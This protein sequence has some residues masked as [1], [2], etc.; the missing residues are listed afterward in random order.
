MLYFAEQPDGLYMKLKAK[1]KHLNI[2][3]SELNVCFDQPIG[4]GNFGLVTLGQLRSGNVLR[5]V[6]VKSIKGEFESEQFFLFGHYIVL[7]YEARKP[8]ANR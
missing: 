8:H 1:V 6:A 5:T 2:S 3:E 4:H 7:S